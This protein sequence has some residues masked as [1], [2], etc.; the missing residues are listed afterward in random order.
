MA[1][2]L[3]IARVAVLPMGL[4]FFV[5]PDGPLRGLTTGVS[6]LIAL[7]AA[8]T[9]IVAALLGWETASRERDAGYTTTFGNHRLAA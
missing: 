2:S 9:G 8:G 3:L 6:L 1:G 7:T 4:G 5:V